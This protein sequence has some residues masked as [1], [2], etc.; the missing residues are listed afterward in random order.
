MKKL[1]FI[2]M[3]WIILDKCYVPSTFLESSGYVYTLE[4]ENKERVNVFNHKG[5]Y[6]VG[7]KVELEKIVCKLG[8]Y[9]RFKNENN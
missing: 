1:L 2:L 8:T 9:W 6:I 4:N 5:S 3:L 7:D